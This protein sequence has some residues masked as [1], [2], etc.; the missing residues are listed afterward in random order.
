MRPVVV[1]PQP[2]S[3][4]MQSASPAAIASDTLSTAVIVPPGTLN[5]RLT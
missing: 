2:L 1:L 5:V 3:P 4:T